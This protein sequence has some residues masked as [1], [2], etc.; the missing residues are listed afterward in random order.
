[1]KKISITNILIIHG[2]LFFVLLLA[3][4]QSMPLGYVTS[5][6]RFVE[7]VER[8]SSSYS[9]KQWEKNDGQLQK[10]IEKYSREKQKLSPDEK[11]KVG[12][13][14]VRY[15]KVR[16]KSMGLNFLGEIGG[17]LDYLK[18]FTDEIMEEIENYQMK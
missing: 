12:E 6:E 10:Y 13:L 9:H 8:N 11:R 3:S 5:F 4:C 1:M 17:W 18:G 7:R 15:Y 16:V 2:G 14:T